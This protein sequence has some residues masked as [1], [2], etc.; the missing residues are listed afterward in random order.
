MTEHIAWKT[1]VSTLRGPA[2]LL[3]EREYAKT[4]YPS[5]I[6][7]STNKGGALPRNFNLGIYFMAA[8][9]IGYAAHSF[10]K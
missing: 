7:D 4:C 9:S 2:D 5:L 3:D 10:I 6:V 1:L 8:I